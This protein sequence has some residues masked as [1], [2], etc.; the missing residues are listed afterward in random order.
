[1]KNTEYIK[2]ETKSPPY[3]VYDA[4][5]FVCKIQHQNNFLK[6][7]SLTK[8]EANLLFWIL[9]LNDTKC[10]KKEFLR[11]LCNFSHDEFNEACNGL[12]RKDYFVK[13]TPQTKGGPIQTYRNKT[14]SIT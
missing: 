9:S 11:E 8:N 10:C 6:D 3:L 2:Q 1:M 13:A 4:T 12:I 7:K 5:K 14:S